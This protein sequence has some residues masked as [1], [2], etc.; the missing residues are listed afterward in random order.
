M[1]RPKNIV[2]IIVLHLHDVVPDIVH[3]IVNEIILDDMKLMM[4]L[5]QDCVC[6]V[7]PYPFRIE[8]LEYFD[9]IGDLEVT[10]GGMPR[11]PFFSLLVPYVH[12]VIWAK[13]VCLVFFNTFEPIRL[14]PESCM[15]MKGV[16]MLYERAASQVPSLYVCPVENVLGRVPLIPFY[17]NGN[18]VDTI[19]HCFRGKIP[20]EAAADS[21]PDSGMG[22]R[23]F[24]INM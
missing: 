4:L 2:T 3:D 22:S 11:G 20:R 9:P 7:A 15:Q 5:V 6:V 10:G 17:L 16:P 8:P 23:L 19:P 24:E 14:T 18:S 1:R 12:L 13:D 21:R